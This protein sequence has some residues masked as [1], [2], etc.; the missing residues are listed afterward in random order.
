MRKTVVVD[1]TE[2]DDLITRSRVEQLINAW[3]DF[4]YG[5]DVEDEANERITEVLEDCGIDY[6]LEDDEDDLI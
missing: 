6:H 2:N 5:Y 1:W 4:A 3:Q